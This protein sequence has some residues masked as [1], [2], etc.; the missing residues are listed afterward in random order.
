MNE[1]EFMEVVN[2]E[3]SKC[4][5]VLKEKAATYS[6]P[7]KDRLE[8]LKLSA[9]VAGISPAKVAMMF[10]L[11]HFTTLMRDP[12]NEESICDLHNYL[13]LVAALNKEAKNG[14]G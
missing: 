3:F 10:A 6:S 7:G 1:K 2:R 11:K 9:A 5:D 8:H 14:V 4:L 12:C 13:F